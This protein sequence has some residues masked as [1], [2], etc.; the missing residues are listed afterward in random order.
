MGAKSNKDKRL[1]I[2][3]LKLCSVKDCDRRHCARGYCALHWQRWRNNIPLELPVKFTSLTKKGWVCAGYRW[4][5]T[6][7][8]GEILEHRYKM[9]Q[10][11]GRQLDPYDEV[12]HHKN[13]DKLDNRLANLE[14]MSR[15]EHTSHHRGHQAKNCLVCGKPAHPKGTRG[16]C[17]MH[18]L[19]VRRVKQK[20]GVEVTDGKM[21][22]ALLDM[23]IALALESSEVS[24]RLCLLYGSGEC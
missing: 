13:G 4:I 8:R 17:G 11:L 5:S 20:L 12:V 6:P 14:L 19:R 15:A 2:N 23:G 18:A 1:T 21:G 24:D 16:L 9:E 3:T 7:D 22:L 10:H